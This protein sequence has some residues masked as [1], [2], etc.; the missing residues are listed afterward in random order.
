MVFLALKQTLRQLA[1]REVVPEPRYLCREKPVQEGLAMA[2]ACAELATGV[3][4]GLEGRVR[5]C[6]DSFSLFSSFPIA[7]LESYT[8][9]HS[10]SG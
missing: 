7:V 8:G 6:E 3:S 2:A 5:S 9:P 4:V 1:R 10:D